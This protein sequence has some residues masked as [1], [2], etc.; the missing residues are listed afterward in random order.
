M[1]TCM[2]EGKR[3]AE[4]RMVVMYGETVSVREGN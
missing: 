2:G 3:G 4:V 1:R